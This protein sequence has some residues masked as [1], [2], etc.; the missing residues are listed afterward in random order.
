MARTLAEIK[1]SLIAAKESES[2]LSG[3]TSTSAV[4]EWMLW[5]N[6]VAF[7]MWIQEGLFDGFKA[8]VN[9]Q[10]AAD[11]SHTKQWYITK[12]KAF[13]YGVSLP[14]DSDVYAVVPPVDDS[15]LIVTQAN[16]V[17]LTNKLRI[18]S[19]KGEPGAL[20]KLSA[21]ELESF[22]T[23][24]NR[25]KDAGVRLELTSGDPDDFK[26]ACQV[27]YD[28]LILTAAGARIDGTAATPVKDAINEY[29]SSLGFD[30]VF[31]LND[32]IA[33]IT[34]V[35]GVKIFNVVSAE[36]NYAATPYVPITILYQPDAGYMTLN[37]TFFD[38]NVGYYPNTL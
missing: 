26:L 7:F 10:I 2:E 36:A 34:A 6:V 9:K 30:G 12:A 17:E 13:Q 23:Y 14:A 3:L 21:A 32:F 28:P 22:S 31:I 16:V 1:A 5:I 18:K 8:D 15:V 37:E 4:A 11:K 19:A 27:F 25:I 33:A 35:E 24:M 29:F 20:E 38:A